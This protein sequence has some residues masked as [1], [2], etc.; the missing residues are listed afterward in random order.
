LGHFVVGYFHAI[1]FV[2]NLVVSCSMLLFYLA[3]T[4]TCCFMCLSF[5]HTILLRWYASFHAL[6]CCFVVTP[7][8]FALLFHFVVSPYCYALLFHFANFVFVFVF[9]CFTLLHHLVASPYNHV[10]L[11]HLIAPP[12]STFIVFVV[13]PCLLSH[14]LVF[15]DKYFMHQSFCVGL[16][17]KNFKLSSS[18]LIR[19]SICF[20]C[21]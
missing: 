9:C 15:F 21:F 19:F 3:T 5:H 17:M 20:F 11:S 8:C 7:H 13:S 10:L 1:V 6:L 14:T 12:W 4:P 18:S 2:F 16:K